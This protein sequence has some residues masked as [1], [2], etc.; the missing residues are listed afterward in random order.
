[1]NK[2]K[3]RGS[4]RVCAW[5]PGA[6]W[7]SACESRNNAS[8]ISLCS[9]QERRNWIASLVNQGQGK[10]NENKWQEKRITVYGFILL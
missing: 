4:R 9:V 5:P 8:L 10:K 2:K 3:E 6:E 7:P 1:M